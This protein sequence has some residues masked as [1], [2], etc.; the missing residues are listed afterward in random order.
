MPASAS[1]VS[2]SSGALAAAPHRR[3]L[4]ICRVRLHFAD[5][6]RAGAGRRS[7]SG[8]RQGRV[9]CGRPLLSRPRGVVGSGPA[10][11]LAVVESAEVSGF[12]CRVVVRGCRC[13]WMVVRFVCVL[14]VSACALVCPVC[15]PAPPGVFLPGGGYD[16][17]APS[18]RGR[19]ESPQAQRPWE[20]ARGKCPGLR[21]WVAT[22]ACSQRR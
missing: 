22:R 18:G 3:P 16:L 12:G 1:R 10:A 19:G 2:S 20:N 13:F 8:W 14:R 5:R 21:C 15:V 4:R 7:G 11:V 6:L 9:R 17:P